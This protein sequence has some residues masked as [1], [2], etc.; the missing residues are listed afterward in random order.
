MNIRRY[1]NAGLLAVAFL[2]VLGSELLHSSADTVSSPSRTPA[3]EYT[4][5]PGFEYF[6]AQYKN[7]ATNIED[8]VENF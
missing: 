2:G 4:P 3:A 8:H 5:S 7:E 6:P 1:I